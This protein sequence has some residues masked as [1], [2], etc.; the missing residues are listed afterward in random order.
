MFHL[1]Q[2]ILQHLSSSADPLI[3]DRKCVSLEEFCYI[4]SQY[5]LFLHTHDGIIIINII[6]IMTFLVAYSIGLGAFT[7]S[8]WVQQI[9][10]VELRSSRRWV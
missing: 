7:M 9:T 1:R 5:R 2:I 10:L 4:F 6:I 3:G 8:M